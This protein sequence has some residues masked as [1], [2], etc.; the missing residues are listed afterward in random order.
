MNWGKFM[1]QV[2]YADASRRRFWQRQAR[3]K[4]RNSDAGRRPDNIEHGMTHTLKEATIRTRRRHLDRLIALELNDNAAPDE[5]DSI[6]DQSGTDNDWENQFLA[7]AEQDVR[8]PEKE[9]KDDNGEYFSLT[10]ARRYLG[11]DF[12]TFSPSLT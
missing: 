5:P 8:D 10:E 11:T 3:A 9:F 12:R 1:V 2:D 4:V 7:D 6:D